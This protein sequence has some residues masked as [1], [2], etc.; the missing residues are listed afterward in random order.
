MLEVNVDGTCCVRE[1]V[2]ECHP[3]AVIACS[4]NR[5]R[6]HIT[7]RSQVAGCQE[8]GDALCGLSHVGGANHW[9]NRLHRKDK[10]EVMGEPME[11]TPNEPGTSS[12]AA[13]KAAPPPKVDKKDNAAPEARR[14]AIGIR[15]QATSR[16]VKEIVRIRAVCRSSHFISCWKRG[17]MCTCLMRNLSQRGQRR[18]NRER[19]RERERREHFRFRGSGEL[20]KLPFRSGPCRELN[21]KFFWPGGYATATKRNL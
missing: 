11:E 1:P 12:T 10:E 14:P 6:W 15:A 18:E 21:R 9:A 13:P 8:A 2:G 5:P 20:I 19:E 4:G 17:S 7:P 16:N 3:L